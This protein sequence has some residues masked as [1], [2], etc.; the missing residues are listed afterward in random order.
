MVSYGGAAHSFTKREAGTDPS[1]GAAYS[2]TADRRSWAHMK[3]F[4]G[5]LFEAVH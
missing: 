2:E 1:P 4:F 3:L 5:E